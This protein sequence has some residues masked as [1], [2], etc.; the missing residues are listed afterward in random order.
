[1][2]SLLTS[3]RGILSLTTASSLKTGQCSVTLPQG[4]F[5]QPSNQGPMVG[6]FWLCQGNQRQ[7]SCPATCPGYTATRQELP[8]SLW[9]GSPAW[10]TLQL[11]LPPASERFCCH[12]APLLS[13]TVLSVT[14]P[15]SVTTSAAVSLG[16]GEMATQLLNDLVP[17][18]S[19][20]SFW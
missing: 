14:E 11:R 4:S 18:S 15:S 19:A 3:G 10:P 8:S 1:M 12:V 6:S 7:V 16:L 5:P 2:G 9:V 20:P 13:A 17:L